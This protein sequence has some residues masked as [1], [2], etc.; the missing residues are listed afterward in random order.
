MSPSPIEAARARHTLAEVARRTGVAVSA[1]S[2]SVTVRCPMP[3]HVHPD[4][5]PSM[6]LYLDDGHY[7]CF[8]C[9]A[10]GDVVQWVRETERVGITEA[11][12]VLDSDAPLTNAWAGQLAAPGATSRPQPASSATVGVSEPVSQAESPDLPRTP[13]ERVDAAL[14]A[15]WDYYSYGPL[16]ARAVAYLATRGIE[17]G[18]LEAHTG[19]AETGHTP[20]KADGLVVA[21]RAKGFSNDALVDAGLAHRRLGG[22]PVTDFYRQRVLIP[23]RDDHGRIAGLIG[24]NIGDPEKWPKYK[25]PSRTCCYDKSVNLYQPL[26]APADRAGQVVV[27][28]GTL[29]AIAIAV[30]AI[31]GGQTDRF[32]PVTQSGRELSPAQMARVLALHP[33]PPVLGF[34]GD[35]AGQDS[36]CRHALAAARQGRAAAVTVLPGDH[37][38][39]SWLSEQGDE[40]LRAWIRDGALDAARPDPK[41]IPAATYVGRHLANQAW[42]RTE[43]MEALVA[44]GSASDRLPPRSADLWASRVATIAGRLAVAEAHERVIAHAQ[45]AEHAPVA[46]WTTW[47][48]WQP[49]PPPESDVGFEAVA[50]AAGLEALIERIA[51]WRRR[52]PRAG[53]T[54][55]FRSAAVAIDE[56]GMAPDGQHALCPER[57]IRQ[58][59]RSIEREAR[60]AIPIV[61][62][63]TPGMVL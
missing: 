26:P 57:T 28:E 11:I 9:A 38:P 39:A 24:R 7:Y 36:A 4:R 42:S 60:S 19:R 54:V 23:I 59:E 50:G 40:G 33:S 13:P 46:E 58:H 47:E 35:P 25:N 22:G 41:P 44:A 30:A 29:D 53:D 16:H 61:S 45:E 48:D 34:D 49:E 17:V 43:R 10:K 8:G 15:A 21:L 55:F 51:V 52:L 37:D 20:A 56:A 14:H 12:R 2:G 63:D 5:T 27:V 3:S 32:C 62:T 18:V 1:D 6:R 31:R